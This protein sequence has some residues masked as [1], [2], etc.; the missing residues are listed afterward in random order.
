MNYNFYVILISLISFNFYS[1][2]RSSPEALAVIEKVDLNMVS[3][4]QT[5]RSKGY[6][7]GQDKNFTEYLSPERE[8]GMKMLKLDD[9]LWIYSPSTDRTIQLSGHLLRQ[10]LMGSDLSYEDMMEEKKLSLIYSVNIIGEELINNRKAWKMELIAKVSN[11]SYYKRLSWI[12]KEKYV[13]L[14]EDLFAKSGE[15]LKTTLFTDIKKING[16]WY[17]TKINYKDVL[18][19]GQ[20]TDFVILEIA[21]DKSIPDNYFSKSILKK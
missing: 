19:T 13:P 10:S 6:S 11:V 18:K 15:L 8:K 3:K 21:F 17:P 20:G 7:V 9:R 14:K 4:S 12:D 5:I 2:E 16:R 1:Q